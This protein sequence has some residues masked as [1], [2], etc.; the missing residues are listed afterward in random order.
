M[1]NLRNSDTD[2][3]N[4]EIKQNPQHTCPNKEVFHRVS[5]TY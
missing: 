1:D 2:Y 5:L 3:A 4:E